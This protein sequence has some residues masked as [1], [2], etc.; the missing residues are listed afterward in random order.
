MQHGMQVMELGMQNLGPFWRAWVMALF[1]VNGLLPLLF[2]RHPEAR[3]MA[4]LTW[5]QG[6]L[7]MA[8]AGHLGFVRLLGVAH[9]AWFLVLP[10]LVRVGRT[11]RDWFGRWAWA[12][13][14]LSA[15]SLAIDVSDVARYLLGDRLPLA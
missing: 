7:M 6:M 1:L 11:Q 3:W 5:A 8:L 14:A 10:S 4:A 2:L 9:F 13:L 15:V 12:A